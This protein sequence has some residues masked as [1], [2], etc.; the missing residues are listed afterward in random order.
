MS[1]EEDSFTHL[2][3]DIGV[4]FL[5]SLLQNVLIWIN[6]RKL[7]FVSQCEY[8]LGL[9]IMKSQLEQSFSVKDIFQKTKY[10]G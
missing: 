3:I 6:I 4:L 10:E 2:L 1:V 9:Y 7:N 5:I 8:N